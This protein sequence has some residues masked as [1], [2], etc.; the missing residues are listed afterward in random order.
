MMLRCQA[1]ET[2]GKD[3]DLPISV[4]A[5][6]LGGGP[7]GEPT[8]LNMCSPGTEVYRN[9]VKAASQCI[10]STSKT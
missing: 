1:P 4:E 10:N 6:L 3:Q 9:G 7:T 2:M 8:T 5:Q